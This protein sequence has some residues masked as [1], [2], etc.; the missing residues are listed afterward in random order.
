MHV[1]TLH[2][3][4]KLAHTNLCLGCSEKQRP[5]GNRKIQAIDNSRDE[6]GLQVPG[7]RHWRGDHSVLGQGYHGTIVEHSQQH[8]Q[9]CGEV[10]AQTTEL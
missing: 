2:S 9:Q 1:A 4:D 3:L 10:P 6:D 5:G 8:N 7:V